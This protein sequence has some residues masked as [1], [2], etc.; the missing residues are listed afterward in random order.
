VATHVFVDN[1][2]AHADELGE[3]NASSYYHRVMEHYDLAGRH[4]AE[5]K[6]YSYYAKIAVRLSAI[7][8]ER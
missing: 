2:A 6:G 4:F 7:Q 3:L 8:H 1:D 5:Q